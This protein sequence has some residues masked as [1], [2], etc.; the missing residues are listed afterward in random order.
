LHSFWRRDLLLAFLPQFTDPARGNLMLQILLLG[1]IFTGLGLIC[2]LM[3][4][5][6]AGAARGWLRK[7]VGFVKAQRYVVGGVF[8]ALGLL[9]ALSGDQPTE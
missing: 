3:W 7:S 6:G 4:A 1:A 2:D 9:A 5:L 8:I